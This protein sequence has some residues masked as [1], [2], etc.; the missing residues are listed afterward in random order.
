MKNTKLI[1]LLFFIASLFLF[2]SC[3]NE[4]IEDFDLSFTNVA[5]TVGP[6]VAPN[7]N[8]YLLTDT[9]A[10]DI[11]S[12]LQQLGASASDIESIKLSDLKLRI[13]GPAGRNFDVIEFAEV[14]ILT[15]T[16]PEDFTKIAYTQGSLLGLTE[17][18]FA[19]QDV[20]LKDLLA[21][22]GNFRLGIWG[23]HPAPINTNTDFSFDLVFKVKVKVTE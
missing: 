7:G 20:N 1:A 3:D 21:S 9:L 15:G 17:V 10:N 22:G 12:Q 13:T 16:G 11:E 6:L 5:V 2:N 19:S 8:E 4:N 18:I 23:Y 14:R